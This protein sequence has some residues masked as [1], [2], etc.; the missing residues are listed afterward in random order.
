MK[1]QWMVGLVA[2]CLA[3]AG[4][5]ARAESAIATMTSSFTDFKYELRSLDAAPAGQPTVTFQ[6]VTLQPDPVPVFN[7]VDKVYGVGLIDVNGQ[8]TD[9]STLV[10]GAPWATASASSTSSDGTLNASITPSS[11]SASGSFDAAYATTQWGLIDFNNGNIGHVAKAGVVN[12]LD[13]VAFTLSPHSVITFTGVLKAS[14][15]LDTA[16]LDQLA[17][18]FYNGVETPYVAVNAANA[19]QVVTLPED[20]TNTADWQS[21][22]VYL[23]VSESHNYLPGVA[24]TLVVK[25]DEKAFTLTVENTRDTA[26]LGVFNLFTGVETSWFRNTIAS[27]EIGGPIST[28]VPEP[29]TYALMGLG[30]IGLAAVAR[31]NRLNKQH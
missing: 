7:N 14:I 22:D 19:I 6:T 16:A 27:P 1:K 5:N 11:L 30:L 13:A 15:S 12:D 31:Q 26:L 10:A 25:S 21:Q 20:L 18:A 24:G 29:S 8:V 28:T 2:S 9:T 23:G 4:V 3:T 17:P